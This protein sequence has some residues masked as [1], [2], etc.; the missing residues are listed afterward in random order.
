MNSQKIKTIL[1][2]ILLTVLMLVLIVNKSLAVSNE[3]NRTEEQK[4][5]QNSYLK[6]L[7]IKGY[8]LY[9]SF[10]KFVNE[11]FLPIP[12]EVTELE[13][14][15][16]PEIEGHE[17]KISGNT[18][19]TKDSS[20]VTI[21][22]HPKKGGTKTTYKINVA[23]QKSNG[24]YLT[25]LKISNGE[26]DSD[27][28]KKYFDLNPEL[29]KNIYKYNVSV[30]MVDEIKNLEIETTPSIEGTKVEIIGNE[31][32]KEGTN[33]VTILLT[34]SN[35]NISTYQLEVKINLGNTVVSEVSKGKLFDFAYNT[36]NWFL[37][38]ISDEKNIIITLCVAVSLLLLIII[39]II[40]KVRKN[41]RMDA[42]KEKLK[43]RAQK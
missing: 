28:N 11:Y 31:N 24:L 27:G 29:N 20:T 9:P 41:R 34:D 16:V 36:K 15:A 39:R 10:N 43:H 7:T 37:G 14:D 26:T 1:S 3:D 40:F 21:V 25:A 4:A 30:S 33:N 2:T 5:D 32:L 38:F 42:K 23:K 17:V 8:E 6:S 13:I 12:S 22:S 18:N 19:I 35:G